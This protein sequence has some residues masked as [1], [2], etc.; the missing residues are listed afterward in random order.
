MR[1][2]TLLSHQWKAATRSA[3]ASKS[4]GIKIFIGFIFFIL[5]LELLG[6]G[7]YLGS[8]LAKNSENP[9]ADLSGYGLYFFL[10]ILM[11]RYM[12]QK[13]PTFMVGPYLSL[14]IK[15]SKLVNFVLT[16]PL[17]NSLNILP[18]SFVLAITMGLHNHLDAHT[19]WRIFAIVIVGDLFV[20]YLSIY[21]KRVQ[22]KHE[23]IFYLFL[24]TVAGLI[25][26]DQFKII[27]LQAISSDVFMPVIHQPLWLLV[28][29]LFFVS[30]Y[31]LNFQLLYKHFTL[32]DFGK[33][34]SNQ[35]SSLENLNY[36][37][38]F[39]KIGAFILLE[40]K[41]CVRNK[42]T[43]SMLF[44]APLFLLYG[45]IFYTN[46]DYQGMNGFL[47]FVGLFISGGFMM[48]FGLYFFAWESGHFDLMLTTN[49]TYKDYIKA[50]Y[51]LMLLTSTIIFLLSTFYIY[52]GVKI[53]I[54]NSVCFLFN[55]GVNSLLLLYFAT[56]NDK[57]MDLSKGSA[58]N[59][60]GV[61]GRHFVLMIPLL[62]APIFIYL[63]FGL[64]DQAG[65]GFAFIGIL[66][67]LG[68]LFREKM[69]DLITRR[70]ISKRYNMSEGFRN[71]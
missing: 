22:I 34:D 58:F 67:I 47:I 64:F 42:R 17:F 19:F 27:N 70:F 21:I 56:N 55:I 69:L 6:G 48:S 4:I 65:I 18:L 46:P 52:F 35:R 25:L 39:G 51:N 8:A 20:N 1:N 60:Q 10:V 59:Y 61:S 24:A 16:K 11:S 26:S 30:A 63:P 12:L 3:S 32:E 43:R 7:Y 37:D 2:I 29:L 23:Y 41:M 62:V 33:G 13:L 40:L 50:K 68:L 49:N 31:Y 53:L 15:K 57:H 54:V 5:F 66:G 44:M 38:R 9:V 71:K 36:L 14:P 28:G 45:L